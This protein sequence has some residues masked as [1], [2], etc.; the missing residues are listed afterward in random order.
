MTALS[1]HCDTANL[2]ADLAL[3]AEFAERSLQVR[4]RLLDLGDLGAHLRCVHLEPG[5]A[6]G[7]GQFGVRLELANG[8]AELVAAIRAGD[9]DGLVADE[10]DR[11]DAQALRATVLVLDAP[12]GVERQLLLSVQCDETGIWA[13]CALAPGVALV[14]AQQLTQHAQA[15]I[16][17]ST[18]D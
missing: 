9:G 13:H 12:P 3:L 17:G 10:V 16:S 15:C 18:D 7:A 6:L 4:Q 5:A 8:L 2:R 1:V 14:L 11:F